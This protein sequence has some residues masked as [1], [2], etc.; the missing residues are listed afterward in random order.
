MNQ[1]ERYIRAAID[2]E[3]WKPVIGKEGYYEV[4]SLGRIR[5]TARIRANGTI[6]FMQKPKI[7]ATTKGG[8]AEN[9][10]RVNLMAGPPKR[11]HAYVHIVVCEAFHGPRPSPL[12]EACHRNDVG[13]DNRAD[14]LKWA[15]HAEN[16]EDMRIRRALRDQETQAPF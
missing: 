3:V 15:T 7:L 12:H 5:T 16:L 1:S 4:S 10:R 2:Y 6:R 9:Y 13:T 11:V 8:R 14:N